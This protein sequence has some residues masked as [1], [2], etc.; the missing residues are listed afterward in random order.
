MCTDFPAQSHWKLTGNVIHI[1]WGKYGNYEL[2][3]AD[4]G[5]SMAGSAVGQ[6]TN[7]R[8]A[9]RV[10]TLAGVSNVECAHDHGH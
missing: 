2:I 5:Q 6:P 9:T 8:K 1:S 4:D 3:V 7:W 10:K